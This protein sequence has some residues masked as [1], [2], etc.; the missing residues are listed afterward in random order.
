VPAA[1]P[2]TVLLTFRLLAHHLDPEHLHCLGYNDTTSGSKLTESQLN[3]AFYNKLPGSKYMIARRS[4]HTDNRSEL[5]CIFAY[6]ST[7]ASLMRKMKVAIWIAVGPQNF[8]FLIND[9]PLVL[10]YAKITQKSRS[11]VPG[12]HILSLS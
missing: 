5:L 8:I 6:R 1:L 12:D 11:I 9:A 7:R 10:L 4:V 3:L 2:Y